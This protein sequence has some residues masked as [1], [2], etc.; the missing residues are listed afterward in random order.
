MTSILGTIYQ[1]GP[2]QRSEIASQLGVTLPTV[3][4]T[5][6]ELLEQGILKEES[7]HEAIPSLGRRASAVDFA[8]TYGYAVGVEWSAQGIV[9][10]VTDLRGNLIGKKIKHVFL[11]GT[12]Y[13]MILDETV[14]CIEILLRELN[15][16]EKLIGAGWTMPGMIEPESGELVRASVNGAAWAHQ[17]IQNDLS[18]L[19]ELP[20]CVNNNVRARAIGQD[21]FDRADR[22]EIYLYYFVQ[23]GVS[24][25]IMAG[26]EPFGQGIY[27]TGDIGHTVMDFNGPTCSCGKNGCLQSFLAEDALLLSA[28]YLLKYGKAPVLS[29]VCADPDRLELS[30]LAIA[31][32]CGDED[33]KR[34]V[35]PAIKYMGIS[36]ANIVNLLNS[37][38]V[39]VDCALM[40]SQS[41]KMYLKDIV[42]ENNL[43]KEEVDLKF[44]FV[45]ANQYTGARGAC[46]MAIEKFVLQYQ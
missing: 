7:I 16:K 38:L 10:C 35:L 4:T 36:I 42:L 25:C 34:L 29:K 37:E 45:Q 41:L 40:S 30:E 12:T 11:S 5:I 24:C 39:V 27:G 33:I 2:I 14:E 44:E 46:A 13:E 9:C 26:G 8:E 23:T 17:S 31:I 6:K 32:E 19:L 28:E 3:T 1:Q 21:M 22:P 18:E 43:F 15:V 20:V